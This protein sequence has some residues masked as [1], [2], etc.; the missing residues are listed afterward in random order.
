MTLQEE[1][2]AFAARLIAFGTSE[3]EYVG[4]LRNQMTEDFVSFVRGS[5][6]EETRKQGM[7]LMTMSLQ[8]ND[9]A[10]QV[11]QH[12]LSL[13]NFAAELTGD[14]SSGDRRSINDL[15]QEVAA[16]WTLGDFKDR[17]ANAFNIELGATKIGSL[18]SSQNHDAELF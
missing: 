1:R 13:M 15:V 8:K 11:E 16:T 7:R 2:A 6:D 18:R 12:I 9:L 3:I 14:V 4:R 5:K 10:S 17:F